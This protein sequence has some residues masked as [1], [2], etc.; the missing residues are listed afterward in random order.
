MERFI[1]QRRATGRVGLDGDLRVTVGPDGFAVV[2]IA[3]ICGDWL[4]LAD[5]IDEC[6]GY[7]QEIHPYHYGP[8]RI[9]LERPE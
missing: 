9:T 2:E 3:A 8:M 1:G 7:G 5:V 4:D 6:F